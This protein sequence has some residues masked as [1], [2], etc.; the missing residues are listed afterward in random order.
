MERHKYVCQYNSPH[1]G[2]QGDS[3]DLNTA[4]TFKMPFILIQRFIFVLQLQEFLNLNIT[5]SS[6]AFDAVKE[7]NISSFIGLYY[8]PSQSTGTQEKHIH[9]NNKAYDSNAENGLY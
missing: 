9:D 2:L 4:P 5:F 1:Q 3:I 8:I 7:I 6:L